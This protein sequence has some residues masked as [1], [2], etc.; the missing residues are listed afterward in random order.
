MKH[1]WRQRLPLELL[2]GKNF[3]V[4]KN[5]NV[6]YVFGALLLLSL[7]LQ[8]I[9]GLWL[10]FFYIP[11]AEQ[12]F[13]S[14]QQLLRQVPCGWIL[15]SL[16][17]TGASA[18]VVLVYLHLLRGLLYRSYRSPR[19]VVWL[20]GVVLLWLL[21]LEAF[22]GYLLPWGQMSY[23]GATVVTNMLSSIPGGQMLAT[24]LRGDYVV[25]GITLQRF[26]A[27][28]IIAL[29]C[30][31]AWVIRL[32]IAAL[33]HVGSGNPSQ[34]SI[35]TR[36]VDGKAPAHCVAFYPQQVQ[37]ECMAWL[38]YL[39][40]FCGVVF[41]VPRGFGFLMDALNENLAN[42]WQTPS[43]IRP[44]WYMAPFY[45]LLRAIPSKIAGIVAIVLSLLSLL[46]IPWLHHLLPPCLV[47]RS[48]KF[49]ITC[50][51]VLVACFIGLTML[52]LMPLTVWLPSVTLSL[53][54]IGVVALV[55]A[56]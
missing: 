44:L 39:G 26:F 38:V 12:A 6:W 40:I 50:L 24:W 28:H 49:R 48:L 47:K 51:S 27:L 53:V 9:T 11:T 33:H 2:I 14:I 34:L 19:E 46:A 15:R 45:A 52:G 7:V 56:V 41:F 3:F 20:L 30:L 35:E 23:W 21:L 31:L 10:T 55:L 22:L 32:H 43:D 18:I 13:G 37:K 42:P 4:P 25:S 1:F 16:H 36:S 17:T 29:P 5:L 54:A 8:V